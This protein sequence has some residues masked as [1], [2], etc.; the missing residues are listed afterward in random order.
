MF[1]WVGL[2]FIVI[3]VLLGRSFVIDMF[4]YFEMKNSTEVVEGTVVRCYDNRAE[5]KSWRQYDVTMD[6]AFER[7]GIADTVN[8]CCMCGGST[9]ENPYISF[10]KVGDK[11]MVRFAKAGADP[12]ISTPDLLQITDNGE[13]TDSTFS[14]FILLIPIFL[15][16]LGS[17]FFW[18]GLKF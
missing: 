3:G 1:K 17:I 15:L 6:V 12:E 9:H 8:I 7:N 2:L 18:V 5:A 16:L 13:Y 4:D 11:K 14:F 10:G